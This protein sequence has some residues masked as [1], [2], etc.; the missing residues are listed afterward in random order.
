MCL[1]FASFH[2]ISDSIRF[3]DLTRVREIY[4]ACLKLVPHKQFT[5]AKLW[6]QFAEFEIR[7]QQLDAARKVMGTAI[8]LAPKEKVR[9]SSF[10]FCSLASVLTMYTFSCSRTILNLNFD[11]VNLI[12][13]VHFIK[14]GLRYIRIVIKLPVQEAYHLLFTV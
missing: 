5:F 1:S 2:M 10:P 13:V 11:Y 4:K 14:S 7:Q 6:T 9:S 12:V 8:G 3:Q